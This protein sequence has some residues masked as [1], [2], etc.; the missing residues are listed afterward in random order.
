MEKIEH[1]GIAVK[2]LNQANKTFQ[3]L[4]GIHPYKTEVVITENV[5][6]S[7]FEIGESKVELLESSDPNSVIA[8]FLEKRGEGLHHIAYSVSNIYDEMKRLKTEGF[9]LINEEPKRGADNKL[10]CFLHP[11]DTNGV[12]MELCQEII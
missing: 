6:T 5:I 11:R 9:V 4:L 12:L 3:K 7:F 1:I 2:D 10:V 8:K